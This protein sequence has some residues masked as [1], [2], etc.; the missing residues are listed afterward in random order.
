VHQEFLNLPFA[1]DTS[2]TASAA[3][4][5][6]G[7]RPAPRRTRTTSSAR[8]RAASPRE[9]R[10]RPTKRSTSASAWR[11]GAPT[12]ATVIGRAMSYLLR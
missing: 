7:R 11:S 8:R 9:P 3:G 4:R 6:P 12:Y 10:S 2:R 1:L 5:S